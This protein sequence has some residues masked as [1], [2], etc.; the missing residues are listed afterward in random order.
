MIRAGQR[1]RGVASA[2]GFEEG[3]GGGGV[4]GVVPVGVVV[5]GVVGA[6]GSE[7]GVFGAEVP[8]AVGGVEVSA[9]APATR[10]AAV[11]VQR[12]AGALVN[13]PERTPPRE[14]LLPGMI[15]ANP[16]RGIERP[17]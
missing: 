5:L 13:A 8:R 3:A 2:Q 6:L 14:A 12:V 9:S 1:R 10:P 15:V 16:L 7:P 4:A 17:S 11:H